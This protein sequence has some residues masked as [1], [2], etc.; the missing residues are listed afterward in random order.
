MLEE[1]LKYR[2]LPVEVRSHSAIQNEKGD[3][4]EKKKLCLEPT[5]PADHHKSA[6]RV[7]VWIWG[8][9]SWLRDEA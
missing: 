9:F 1:S 6:R 4:R 3:S 2:E 8:V 5:A 7:K